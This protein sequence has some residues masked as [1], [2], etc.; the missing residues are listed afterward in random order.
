ML[1][2]FPDESDFA[3]THTLARAEHALRTRERPPEEITRPLLEEELE[4][5]DEACE[6]QLPEARRRLG[7]TY[8]VECAE[9][10]ERE[11]GGG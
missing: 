8:C 2:R 11:Q 1:E 5:E 7:F 9:R 6:N 3:S 10:M 4:C